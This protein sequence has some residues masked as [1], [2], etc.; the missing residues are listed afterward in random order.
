[1]AGIYTN[2]NIVF[3]K[4]T[5]INLPMR[6][7]IFYQIWSSTFADWRTSVISAWEWENKSK[8][9]IHAC[10]SNER[11]M[12]INA[13]NLR[14]H[15]FIENEFFDEFQ[16]GMNDLNHKSI[17]EWMNR[18]WESLMEGKRKIDNI[19]K[20]FP[21]LSVVGEWINGHDIVLHRDTKMDL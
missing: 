15:L 20:K 11:S 9:G 8:W 10:F 14:I 17:G 6:G 12:H 4:I 1:M 5:V 13:V 2:Q 16:K 3:F 18:W 21:K 19:N 7:D